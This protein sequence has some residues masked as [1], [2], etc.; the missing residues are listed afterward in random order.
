MKVLSATGVKKIWY[1]KELLKREERLEPNQIHSILDNRAS[2]LIESLKKNLFYQRLFPESSGFQ[3]KPQKLLKQFPILTKEIIRINFRNGLLSDETDSK[4]RLDSTSGS[5][6]VPLQF[7]K[8]MG[9]E[10]IK[11]ATEIMFSEYTGWRFGEKQAY[12]WA[13]HEESKAA[14][15]WKRYFLRLKQFPPYFSSD[16]EAHLQLSQ[17]RKWNPRL[18]TGYSSA[19]YSFSQ[20]FEGTNL[21][22]SLNGVIASAE[23]LYP[24]QKKAVEEK[25]NAPV[26]MRYGSREL[27]NVAMECSEREGYHILQSRYIVEILD[28]NGITV[29]EEEIGHIVV[30]DLMNH[31]MPF[32]RYDTGDEG[33]ITYSQCPCGRLSPRLLKLRGRACD[34]IQLPSKTK[35]PALRFNVLFEQMGNIIHEFQIKQESVTKILLRVVPGRLFSSNWNEERTKELITSLLSHEMEVIIEVV[36]SIPRTKSGKFKYIIPIE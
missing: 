16:S 24:Y 15:I 23:S 18:L 20:H 29:E 32:V 34:Y 8:D 13:E 14:K 1:W 7:A 27:D 22:E 2:A 30:T 26:F 36:D 10:N 31:V 28:D 3:G 25:F 35:V 17:I 4:V 12:L 33:S 21:L 6:G 11:L 19:L 5:T 9:A